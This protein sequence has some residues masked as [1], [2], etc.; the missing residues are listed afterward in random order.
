MEGD[1]FYFYGFLFSLLSR[2]FASPSLLS[3][4]ACMCVCVC[5]SV[6]SAVSG[7]ARCRLVC[8]LVYHSSREV[9]DVPKWQERA[10]ARLT[11]QVINTVR[12]CV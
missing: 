3:A 11:V 12:V 9:C 2:F 4:R 6:V 10:T 8:C 1:A 7:R 5:A